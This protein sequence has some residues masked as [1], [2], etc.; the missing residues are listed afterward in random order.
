MFV[1]CKCQI[2]TSLKNSLNSVFL[3]SSPQAVDDL[4]T[5]SVPDVDLQ[6]VQCLSVRPDKDETEV[7]GILVSLSADVWSVL[8][9]DRS[10]CKNFE[11]LQFTSRFKTSPFEILYF[12][13]IG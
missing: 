13:L 2:L 11:K 4:K 6:A 3:I 1:K 10:M 8:Q 5:V 12:I 7:P 9:L